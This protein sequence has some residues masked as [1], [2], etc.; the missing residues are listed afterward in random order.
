MRDKLNDAF[1][2]DLNRKTT[3]I[4]LHRN[5]CG[6]WPNENKARRSI[7]RG[8]ELEEEMVARDEGRVTL[9]ND[10]SKLISP[11][12]AKPHTPPPSLSITDITKV[13]SDELT[14]RGL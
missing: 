4:A 14:K 9:L 10:G 1:W 11:P 3:T 13:I 12:G 7:E 2:S 5:L 8:R 6:K